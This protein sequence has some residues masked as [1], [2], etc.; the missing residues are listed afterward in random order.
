MYVLNKN[1]RTNTVTLSAESGLYSKNLVARDINLIALDKIE[2]RLKI[3]AKARYNQNEQP[4]TAEQSG[5]NELH[6]EFDA[7][8]R[9]L[10]RG[11]SAVLY[12]GDIVV[13]G[14]IIA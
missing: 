9:A 11:Q 4:A 3:K 13:G 7:P 14:G 1:A 2:G 5:E 6:I 12:D 10:T 8:Q